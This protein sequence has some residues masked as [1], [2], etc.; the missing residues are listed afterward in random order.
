[1]FGLYP[2]VLT[3]PSCESKDVSRGTDGTP[4]RTSHLSYTWRSEVLRGLRNFHSLTKDSSCSVGRT[5]DRLKER[6]VGKESGRRSTLRGRE[7]SMF[8]QTNVS[9]VS[10]LNM[11]RSMKTVMT[12]ENMTEIYAHKLLS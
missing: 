3:V 1:M 2:S 6:R 8:R 9:T 11:I 12:D 7:R 10:R 5:I 4:E